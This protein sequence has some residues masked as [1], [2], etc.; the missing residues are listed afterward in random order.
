[1]VAEQWLKRIDRVF[2][3][4]QCDDAWK[5]D[6][7]ISLL[8]EDAYEWWKTFPRSRVQPPV[9][10]WADFL[11]EFRKKQGQ[12]KVDQEKATE[13]EKSV[14][15]TF[16]GA[17][18]S[19]SK[20]RRFF[21]SFPPRPSSVRPQSSSAGRGRGRGRGSIS[22]S[23]GTVNQT[24]PIG[25]PARVYTMRQRQDDDSADV[26]A[27]IF[28][29]FNHDVYMLFDPGSSYS[30]ISAGISCY[31][32]VPCLRLGY[33]VLVSSP[34][35]QEVIANKLYHDCPLVIQGHVFL[36][37]LVEMPS[38]DFDVILGMDWLKKFQ[39]VVDC[40]LKK[41]IFKLPKYV[42]VVIQGGRQILPS[43]VITTTLAQKLIRQKLIR[44]GCE[45]YLAHMVDT[46][47][48]TPNLKDI[49]T[50]CDFPDV[51]PEELPGLPPER[52]VEF[53]I[54]VMTGTQSI[55]IT[56]Y[57]MAPAELKELKAQLQE[58]LDKGFIRPS[59]SPWGAPAMG[60]SSANL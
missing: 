23:Q 55:S 29:L 31:A 1:M 20:K 17:S 14:R 44:H 56:P 16:P 52:E 32:S 59:V 4:L 27:G 38:R 2:L 10:T 7:A 53:E 24:E 13:K 50:M 41:I 54:E 51:F 25:V 11:G 37:N 58:L 33:D 19:S 6:Y 48:G 15:R 49:L 60:S 12:E 45:A 30:Y 47:V 43:S 9:L 5:Y 3:K 8:Q 46:R 22:G 34:L 35:G 18:S 21:G 36:S 28:S 57:R 26:V 39:A 40:D 42:N